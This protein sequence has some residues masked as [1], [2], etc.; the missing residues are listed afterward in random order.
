MLRNSKEIFDILSKGKFISINSTDPAVKRYYEF[1]EENCEDYAEYYH[2]IGFQLCGGDGYWY[3]SRNEAKVDIQRKLDRMASWIDIMDFL[4]TFNP[5]FASGFEFT[6]AD[7]SVRFRSDIELKEKAQS[8]FKG[9]KSYDEIVDKLIDELSS[10]GFIE[11]IS[12]IEMTYRVTSAF[13][14]MEE[15]IDCFV[16]TEEDKDEVLE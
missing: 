16:I 12:E 3:F 14:Y 2:G 1:L 9:K 7:I 11:L 13:H 15:T 5:G 6:A 10:M 8:L 4:K